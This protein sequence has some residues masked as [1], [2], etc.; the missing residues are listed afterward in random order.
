MIPVAADDFVRTAREQTGPVWDAIHAHPFVRGIGDG[1]LSRARWAFYLREDHAY[2]SDLCRLLGLAAAR[3]RD[4]EDMRFFSRLLATTLDVEIELHLRACAALGIDRAEL[5]NPNPSLVTTGYAS[6]LLRTA[7]EGNSADVIAGLLPCYA[8][9]VEIAG[10]LRDAGL[11]EEPRCRE[12]IETY[13]SAGMRDIAAWLARRMDDHARAGTPAD[14]A[15]WL[16]QYSTSARFELLFFETC[17]SLNDDRGR[18]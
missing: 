9:Y 13:V 7:Y 3:A 14:Q 10:R 2:L 11:P 8:G 15:R 17:W 5:E 16:T 1:T 18:E 12:W 6:Y 4:P